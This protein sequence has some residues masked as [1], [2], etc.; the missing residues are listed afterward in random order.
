MPPVCAWVPA[1]VGASRVTVT[2]G[3]PTT[4]VVVG[5][6]AV[7]NAAKVPGVSLVGGCCGALGT[8]LVLAGSAGSAAN[9]A[10]PA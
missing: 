4:S 10:A 9:C 7:V 6:A 3:A 1:N 2:R 8:S 5:S